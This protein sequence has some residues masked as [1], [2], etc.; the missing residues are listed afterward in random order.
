MPKKYDAIVIGAGMSGLAAGIR[1][2]MFDKKVCILEKHVISG[3]LNSYYKRQGHNFDVGL[4]AM[5]NFV[6]KGTKR[7]P[8]TKLL[9]QLRIPYETFELNEQKQSKIVFPDKELTFTNNL[10]V[11]KQEVHEK[12]P[13]QIDG[14]VKL[15][16]KIENFNEVALDNETVMA[17]DVV[18]QYIS[19]E[20]LLEM[21]FCPL[22]IYG[23][24]WENDMDFSQFVIMFKSIYMEGFCRPKGGVRTVID[25]LLEKFESLGG[26]LLFR[27]EVTKLIHKDGKIQGVELKKGDILEAPVVLSSMGYP[28]TMAR[29]EKEGKE[30]PAVGKMTF[31]ESIMILDKKPIDMDFDT[32]IIFYN[33]RDKYHYRSPEELYDKKSAVIC[34]P[35]NF[36]IDDYNE[37]W[38]RVTNMAN[39]DKWK[40][41]E[42]PLYRQMKEEVFKDSV[43]I[44]KNCL[45]NF[46]ANILYK[47]V[48]SPTTIQRYT[49]H[50]GGTVYG[51]TDKSRDGKTSIDG[52]YLIGT[53][54]G[55]LG[56]VGSMLSGISMANLYG[57]ME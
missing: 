49:G 2:A 23:S 43:Q 29:I 25:T 6:P 50:F 28:E 15:L 3:G 56:I 24:A 36:E 53:D 40:E 34:F 22:L 11:L 52:L 26:E 35:N 8:L 41:L 17:K 19:N 16:V 47:D 27:H 39:F 9:K 44:T 48:F 33:E 10:E 12:F 18:A 1:L 31:T 5:T 51:S 21:I 4:H 38:I 32:T 13:D 46:D 45:P 20:Q 7:K 30:N 42:K 54:Q 55:F 37:G 14:F 57:L